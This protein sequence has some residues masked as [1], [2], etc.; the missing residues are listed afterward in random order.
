MNDKRAMLEGSDE[1]LMTYDRLQPTKILDDI[2]TLKVNKNG[3]FDVLAIPPTLLLGPHLADDF[4]MFSN[5]E[6]A[7]NSNRLI[8]I[9]RKNF[10]IKRLSYWDEWVKNNP[11]RVYDGTDRE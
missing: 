9:E 5:R 11:H 1:E 3:E 10:L 7:I 6:N 8:S 2:I 4:A